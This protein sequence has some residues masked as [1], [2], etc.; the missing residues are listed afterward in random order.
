[1]KGLPQ[2]GEVWEIVYVKI[3]NKLRIFSNEQRDG[4]KMQ[5]RDGFQYIPKDDGKG[6]FSM[7]NSGVRM[8]PLEKCLS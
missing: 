7:E 1:M 2:P 3:G 6:G 5:V 4:D 8:P